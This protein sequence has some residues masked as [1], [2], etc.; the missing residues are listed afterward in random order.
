MSYY[1]KKCYANWYDAY[2]FVFQSPLFVLND[3]WRPPIKQDSDRKEHLSCLT[4]SDNALDC[5]KWY[6]N[7]SEKK[8]NTGKSHLIFYLIR[9]VKLCELWGY[10]INI[11]LITNTHKNFS[12]RFWKLDI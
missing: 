9:T 4:T 5:D 8:K 3:I 7:P 10:V 12:V 6:G 1:E 2:L 11:Y